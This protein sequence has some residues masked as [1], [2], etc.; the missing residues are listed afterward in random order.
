MKDD[1]RSRNIPRRLKI[2]RCEWLDPWSVLAPDC[3]PAITINVQT[4]GKTL[5]KKY[6]FF[7]QGMPEKG[8]SA[9]KPAHLDKKLRDSLPRCAD[10]R[11]TGPGKYVHAKKPGLSAWLFVAPSRIELLSKV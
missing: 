9:S 5:T 2:K 4:T 8:K 1:Y 3:C 10:I 7:R 11:D 6:L